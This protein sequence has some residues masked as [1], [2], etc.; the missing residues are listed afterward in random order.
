VASG[1]DLQH[2]SRVINV[3]GERHEP[4][5]VHDYAQGIRAAPGEHAGS[6]Y[7]RRQAQPYGLGAA[8]G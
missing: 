3:A 1:V 6:V 5:L 7:V 2:V 8:R 4:L